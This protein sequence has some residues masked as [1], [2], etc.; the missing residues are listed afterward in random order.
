MAAGQATATNLTGSAKV[1]D[2]PV[3][4]RGVSGHCTVAGV[5]N[6]RD[7]PLVGSPV[8]IALGVAAGNVNV[9]IPSDL[10]VRFPDGCYA[11]FASSLAGTFV[12][13]TG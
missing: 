12:V 10:A 6:L 5:L 4:F 2:D 8:K 7:G 11:E 13:W 3:R 1:S 9:S